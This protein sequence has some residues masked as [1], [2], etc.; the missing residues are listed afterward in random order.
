MVQWV[1]KTTAVREWHANSM[2][3]SRAMREWHADSNNIV[4]FSHC[5]TRGMAVDF[6]THA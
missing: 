1:K 5:R 3:F 6:S 4:P 2:W